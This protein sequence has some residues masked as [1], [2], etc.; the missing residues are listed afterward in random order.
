MQI[1]V[2]ALV[3]LLADFSCLNAVQQAVFLYCLETRPIVMRHTADVREIAEALDLHVRTV[4]RSIRAIR[5][6]PML[7]KI[8]VVVNVNRKQEILHEYHALQNRSLD[9]V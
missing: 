7:S 8:V 6:R 4:Q 5:R 2:K 1:D 9:Q 3:P